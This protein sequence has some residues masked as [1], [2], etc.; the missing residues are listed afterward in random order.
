MHTFKKDELPMHPA[1]QIFL[2]RSG[3]VFVTRNGT[4]SRY[5]NT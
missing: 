3:L 4:A 1:H 5:A 2:R